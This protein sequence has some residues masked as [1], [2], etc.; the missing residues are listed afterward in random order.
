MSRLIIQTE[1]LLYL[2]FDVKVEFLADVELNGVG[3]CEGVV[4]VVEGELL[5]VGF[6]PVF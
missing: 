6:L 4:L 1:E 2:E 5:T 3:V